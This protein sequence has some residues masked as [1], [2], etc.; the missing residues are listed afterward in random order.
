VVDVIPSGLFGRKNE[1]EFSTKLDETIK[2]Q[3][4]GKCYVCLLPKVDSWTVSL[5]KTLLV[6]SQS[7]IN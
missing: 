7:S 5:C 6:L 3:Y 2:E 4:C 1:V